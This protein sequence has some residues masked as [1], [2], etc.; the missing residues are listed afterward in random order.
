MQDTVTVLKRV[1]VRYIFKVKIYILEFT[2]FWSLIFT[3]FIVSMFVEEILLENIFWINQN[4]VVF[5]WFLVYFSGKELISN[6]F[7]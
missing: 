6:I 1:Q 7:F 4:L 3:N 2:F 5:F